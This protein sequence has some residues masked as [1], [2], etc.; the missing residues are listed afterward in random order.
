MKHRH[1]LLKAAV[2]GALALPVAMAMAQGRTG[3]VKIGINEMLSGAFVTVGVPAAAGVRMAAKEINEKGFVVGGTT[4]RLQLIEVD[5]KSATA[6]AVAGMTK[7]VEDDKV[8][9]VFG[10]TVGALASQTQEVG[11]P[12]KVLQFSAATT[13][14]GAGLLAPGAKTTTLMGTQ[15]AINSISA[16]DAEGMKQFGVKKV[17]WISPDDET[18]KANQGPFIEAMKAAGIAVVPILH[19]PKSTDYSSYV[20]RAKGEDVDAIYFLYPQANAADILRAI[21]ELKVPIKVFGSRAVDP[22][23]AA[24]TAIGKP[25]PFP[26]FTTLNTPSI[27]YP[28]TPK[29]KAFADRL[30]AFDPK[31]MGST[32]NFTFFSYDFVHMLVEAMQKAGTVED[33]EKI[34]ATMTTFTH[35]GVA[36]KICYNNKAMRTASLEGGMIIV[37]DGKIEGKS[38]PSS[39]R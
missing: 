27:D 9:F 10:P 22:N 13:W 25:L 3:T 23:V 28:G 12:A 31:A 29:V 15:M 38:I 5:N 30:R 39:C 33:T 4:Y 24:K 26:F 21:V 14:Q 37:R 18:T 2:A 6:D 35:D 36:G 8:K 20:S 34:A 32:A 19:P 7:L 17:A 16:I 1:S 11:S